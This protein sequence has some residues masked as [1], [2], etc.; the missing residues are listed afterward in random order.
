M[1]SS[2]KY[3]KYPQHFTDKDP[4]DFIKPDQT[5]S[6]PRPKIVNNSSKTCFNADQKS[7]SFDVANVNKVFSPKMKS[8]VKQLKTKIGDILP[9]VEKV[10][11]TH[12]K[13][14]HQDLDHKSQGQ[15][16]AQY[17]KTEAV[18]ECDYFTRT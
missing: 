15:V 2:T 4:R 5:D 17:E 9:L 1:Q 3:Y 8:G 16:M 6:S 18:A 13:A 11:T 10:D 12:V 14:P 7:L